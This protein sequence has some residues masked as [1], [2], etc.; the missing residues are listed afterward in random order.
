M[1]SL[2]AKQVSIVM[3]YY[4]HEHFIRAAVESV[5]TQTVANWE[6]IIVDDCSPRAAADA[7][8]TLPTDDRIK[9]FRNQSVRGVSFSRNLAV[10]NSSGEY[11]LP[12]DSDDLLAPDFLAKT[13]PMMQGQ[14]DMFGGV[15]VET[16]VF[17]TKNCRWYSEK[18]ELPSYLV[19]GYPWMALIKKEVFDNVGGYREDLTIGEDFDFFVTALETGWKFKGIQEPLF[20]YRKH[21]D[22]ATAGVRWLP[23][24]LA[25]RHDATFAEHQNQLV[26]LHHNRYR[27]EEEAFAKLYSRYKG[28]AALYRKSFPGA[29][30]SLTESTASAGENEDENDYALQLYFRNYH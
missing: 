17:G 5:L 28:I 10:R 11:L 6:L 20:H 26:E 9:M 25:S 1:N 3:P 7:L 30:D 16:Q 12:L 14:D 4:R 2:P 27:K 22:T 19:S 24:D 18:F 23:L 29:L 8:S 13:L 15:Y 21:E